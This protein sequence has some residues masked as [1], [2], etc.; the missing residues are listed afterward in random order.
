[1]LH[2][3]AIKILICVGLILLTLQMDF[4]IINGLDVTTAAYFVGHVFYKPAD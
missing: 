3:I 4:W 1:M 2:Q